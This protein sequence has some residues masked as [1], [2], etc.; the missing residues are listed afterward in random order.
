[1]GTE[2]LSLHFTHQATTS[3]FISPSSM[4]RTPNRSVQFKGD[5]AK[6][7]RLSTGSTEKTRSSFDS[8]DVPS[9]ESTQLEPP[10]SSRRSRSSSGSTWDTHRLSASER[11]IRQQ[12][13]EARHR[14]RI[15]KLMSHK[16]VPHFFE[17]NYFINRLCGMRR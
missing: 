4:D 6:E 12:N 9:K 17:V 1:M 13:N 14:S 3:N 11:G 10:S 15:E 7:H 5:T 2:Y 8:L 16:L